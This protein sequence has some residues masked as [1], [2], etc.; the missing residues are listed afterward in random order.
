MFL[1]LPSYDCCYYYYYVSIISFLVFI[2]ASDTFQRLTPSKF[3]GVPK[4]D[5]H[6]FKVGKPCGSLLCAPATELPGVHPESYQL[7][8]T[9]GWEE[10]VLGHKFVLWVDSELGCCG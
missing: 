5:I 8:L 4:R 3:Q 7:V 10:G 9:Q 2:Y 1:K 6:S